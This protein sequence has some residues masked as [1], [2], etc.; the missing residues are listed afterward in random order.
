MKMRM[1]V[2]GHGMKENIDF[3]VTDIDLIDMDK[4]VMKTMDRVL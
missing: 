2:Q 3:V 1:H 4:T